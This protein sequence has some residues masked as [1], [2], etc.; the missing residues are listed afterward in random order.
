MIGKLYR[1]GRNNMIII[2]N[3]KNNALCVL[4]FDVTKRRMTGDN[5]AMN[6]I[7]KRP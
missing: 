6:L 1:V 4:K 7:K 3:I 2:L 5:I